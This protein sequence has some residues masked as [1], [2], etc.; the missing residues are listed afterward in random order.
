MGLTHIN[1][2]YYWS[3]KQN[4]IFDYFKFLAVTH[5]VKAKKNFEPFLQIVREGTDVFQQ[6]T[7][8]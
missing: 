3:S 2:F 7:A 8:F 1:I 4:C 6:Q 5:A